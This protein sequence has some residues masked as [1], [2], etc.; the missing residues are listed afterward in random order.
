P[1]GGLRRRR[2]YLGS[3]GECPRRLLLLP[4]LGWRAHVELQRRRRRQVNIL[5][6]LNDTEQPRGID[7]SLRPELYDDGLRVAVDGFDAD[8]IGEQANQRVLRE[9]ANRRGGRA[10]PIPHLFDGALQLRFGSHACEPPVDGQP[11][12][13]VGDVGIV[14]PQVDAQVYGRADLVLYLLALQLLDR[15]LEEL[16]IHVESDRL[17]VSAL[18][19]AEQIACPADLEVERR[20]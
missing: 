19:A 3:A 8:A 1:P 6:P 15:L 9:I 18:L 16:H 11:L 13:H 14:D 10:I 20:D 7:L 12:V 2:H 5:S 4:D 17:D